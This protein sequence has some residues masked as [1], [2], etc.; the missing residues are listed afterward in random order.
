[1]TAEKIGML[2]RPLL[3]P[4]FEQ[5]LVSSQRQ[6]VRITCLVAG[7][8]LLA[9]SAL[10]A[11]VVPE[12]WELLLGLRMGAALVFA[13]TAAYLYRHPV[14]PFPALLMVV[15][16][17]MLPI[18]VGALF[19]GGIASPYIYAALLPMAGASL[20]VPLRPLQA[21]AVCALVLAMVYV[22]IAFA[23]HP[24][25]GRTLATTA[26]F[27]AC[28]SVLTMVGAAIRERAFHDEYQSRHSAARQL[29][30]AN[31]GMLAAGLAHELATP[32]V[33]VGFAI[34][35][36]KR[37]PELVSRAGRPLERLDR[38]AERMRSVLEAMRRGTRNAG[39]RFVPVDLGREIEQAL[40]LFSDRLGA[41]IEL[42]R[43]VESL[44]PV[45]AEPTLVGQILVN[46]LLNAVQALEGRPSPRR[47][48]VRLRSDADAAVLEI[49]DNGPGVPVA[50]RERI[51]QPLFSTKGEEGTGL[52]LWLCAEMA[53]AHEGS[54]T[55]HEGAEG[56]AR[57]RLVLPRKGVR[58]ALA[59]YRS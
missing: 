50:I 37:D 33:T 18:E 8:L 58:A 2:E 53:R 34:E 57:F 36:L 45:L 21:G 38:S 35:Q 19:S 39:S 15:G 30:L 1:M 59:G 6:A 29:G 44:P 52:G 23:P 27:L 5:E 32:M 13:G 17:V 9:F 54:L 16:V 22:P 47:I 40:V 49:E 11:L 43:E 56:G 51:F 14:A 41:G 24:V 28:M 12:A 26:S 48:T 7:P 55:V 3:L 4:T 20:L 25:E 46:L 31:L 10:D 42:S